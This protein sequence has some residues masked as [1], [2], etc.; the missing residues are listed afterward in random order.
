MYVCVDIFLLTPW[1]T[2]EETPIIPSPG[3]GWHVPPAAL[4][5]SIGSVPD[6]SSLTFPAAELT[7]L[8]PHP[9]AVRS[10]CSGWWWWGFTNLET[11]GASEMW[12]RLS[13]RSC[14]VAACDTER[15][16]MLLL[17]HSAA[18]WHTQ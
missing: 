18:S 5:V 12:E 2:R 16:L 14:W 17:S 9:S 8:L 15:L 1:D 13:C 3:V 11:L 6:G 7:L 4:G 10:V